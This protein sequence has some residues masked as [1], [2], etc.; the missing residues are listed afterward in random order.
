ML[1]VPD[2]VPHGG[3]PTLIATREFAAGWDLGGECDDYVEMLERTKGV[4]PGV[5]MFR[6][7]CVAGVAEILF[8]D[9][10]EPVAWYSPASESG[11]MLV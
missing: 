11:A 8:G 2:P 7:E 1:I 3:S 9:G 5:P 6:Y 10:R 4:Y